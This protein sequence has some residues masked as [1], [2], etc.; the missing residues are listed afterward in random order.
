MDVVNKIV[1]GDTIKSV[2]I[3]RIGR[4][5]NEFKTDSDAFFKMVD[6]AKSKVLENEKKKAEEESEWIKKNLPGASET[7]SGVKFKITS[8]GKGDKLSAGSVLKIRY[9]GKVLIDKIS[10]VSTSDQGKPDFAPNAAEFEYV[11]GTSKI[12]EGL[13]EIISGMKIGEKRIVIVPANLAYANFGFYGKFVEGQKRMV[14]STGSTL[15]YE[16]EILGMKT[17]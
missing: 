9:T 1:Q 8:E 13:D 3:T 5:A 7:A 10:F 11:L 14:I 4:N 17:N 6:A 15:Y 16:I 12:N 2:S